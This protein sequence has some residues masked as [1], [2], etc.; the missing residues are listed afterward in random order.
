V[1]RTFTRLAA[2][3]TVGTALAFAQ[4]TNAQP[5][6][7]NPAPPTGGASP[8]PA[9]Q[10]ICIVNIAKVL[11]DYNK[12]NFKGADITRRRQAYVTQVQALR[13]QLAAVNADFQKAANPDQKKALQEKA[14]GIQR[15]IEDIDRTAQAELTQLSNDTIVQV[16][17]E[18]KG[19]IT[20]IAKTN[21]LS[22]VLAY[23]AA[24]KEAEENSPQV[25]QLMLQTPALIPF[26]HRGMDIT[27][28]V[29][30]TLNAR[31]PSPPAPPI[32]TVGGTEAPK[33]PMGTAAPIPGM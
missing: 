14:L 16:Y 15:K 26:Y 1:N 33:S 17:Q 18:I 10:R 30:Q 11:R 12:A 20:D 5:P 9:S 21:N 7:G 6:T 31:Y 32:S 27:D 22:M 2:L 25:A 8:P 23:P 13:D 24:T 3:A 19:V 4:A 29:V 28:V